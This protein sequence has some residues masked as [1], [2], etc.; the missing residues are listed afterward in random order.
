M[1]TSSLMRYFERNSRDIQGTSSHLVREENGERYSEWLNSIPMRRL[2]TMTDIDFPIEHM[3]WISG[4]GGIGK[5][6]KNLS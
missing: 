5:D 2:A 6:V 4:A 1:I 3:S